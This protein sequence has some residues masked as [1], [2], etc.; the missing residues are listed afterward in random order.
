MNSAFSDRPLRIGT[1]G[2]ALALAQVHLAVARLCEA[3]RDLPA[4]ET[5][6]IKTMGDRV[7][8]RPLAEIGGKGLF[9]KEIEAALL[10]GAIDCAVHSLK[11]LETRLPT[12]LVIAAVLARADPRDALIAPGAKSLADLP[13]G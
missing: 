2:S 11:D 10:E 8:D 7:Q 1:R 4:P 12:G 13:K 6:V 9:A 3:H 5:V